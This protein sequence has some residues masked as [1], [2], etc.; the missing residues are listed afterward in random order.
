MTATGG[1][2]R[3]MDAEQVALITGGGSGFGRLLAITLA[4]RGWRVFTG[5]RGS[6]GGFPAVAEATTAEAPDRIRAVQLDVT[7]DASVRAAVGKVLETAGRID[8]LVN[9]AGIGLLGPLE[10]T[11]VDQARRIYETNV[12]GMMRVVQAVV[13]AM[14][15]Q[16][17][18]TILNFGS[19]V[20][21]RANFFQGAYAGS[22]FAVEGMSQS[23][24]WELQQWGI[25]VAVVEPGWYETDFGSSLVTT[26]ETGD[27][28]PRYAALVDA[29]NRG[30][31]AVEGPN[32]A[33][34]EVADAIVE[35]L[36]A[37]RLPFRI[38]VGWNPVRMATVRRDAIDTYERDLFD[39][40]GLG[41]FRSARAEAGDA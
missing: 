2:T 18:G 38:P 8:L 40:Y 3:D 29:W 4:E 6:R 5:F 31:E 35:A 30:V 11:P 19:D 27:A 21:V 37:P 7:D 33:P 22:K 36:E 24:R 14:R 25:R 9:A 13:P 23:M 16:G 34:Q 1:H 41:E 15:S 39:Y 17:G 32:F 28:A 12:F 20:G 10:C 26:F